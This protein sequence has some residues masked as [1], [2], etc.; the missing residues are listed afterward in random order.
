MSI[1]TT[2]K[3]T[4]R[5]KHHHN[6]K[7]TNPQEPKSEVIVTASVAEPFR[8]ISENSIP[9]ISDVPTTDPISDDAP[10]DTAGMA[11][12]ENGFHSKHRDPV[13]KVTRVVYK[14][15]KKV[16]HATG[17]VVKTATCVALAPLVV[18][19]YIGFYAGMMTTVNI[20]TSDDEID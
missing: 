13:K 9:N 8:N 6:R 12:P 11:I 7:S 15:G 1:P 2:L 10:E 4:F 17:T 19:M 3:R 20:I 16:V 14:T 18:P 5:A